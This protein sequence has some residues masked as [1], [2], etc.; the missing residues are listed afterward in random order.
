MLPSR[1]V[2]LAQMPPKRQRQNQ[3]RRPARPGACQPQPQPGRP[4]RR[5]AVPAGPALV[6][7]FWAWPRSTRG[8]F[9]FEL[10]GN[11]FAAVR[12]VMALSEQLGR[13]IAITQL[14]QAPILADLAAQ[15]EAA[16]AQAFSHLV[17]LLP[18][19][20]CP[21]A[22]WFHLRRQ[23]A[24]LSRPGPKACAGGFNLLGVQAAKGA[25][26]AQFTDFN[27]MVNAYLAAILQRQPQGLITWAA[28][29]W[30]A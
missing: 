17:E 25:A 22:F 14:V 6:R 18:Q 3:P 5:Y 20:N 4:Q 11:S 19:N 12:L 16:Q 13:D 30:A 28:G 27:A 2:P 7:D 1:W 24:L 8:S 15:L 29:P 23:C 21:D 26:Q 10:G 9:F